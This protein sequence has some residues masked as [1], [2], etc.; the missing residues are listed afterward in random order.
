LSEVTVDVGA[1]LNLFPAAVARALDD[2]VLAVVAPHMYGCPAKIAEIEQLCRDAGVFLIDDAAH[3]VEAGHRGRAL[4]RFGDVGVISFNQSKSIVTGYRGAGGILLVNNPALEHALRDRLQRLPQP[5]NPVV[6]FLQ[7]IWDF[8][9]SEYLGNTAYYLR[10]IAARLSP[11]APGAP[12]PDYYRPACMSNLGAAIA[13]R[14]LHRFPDLRAGRMRVAG[15]YYREIANMAGVGFP[16]YA[17]DVYLSRIVLLMPEHVNVPALRSVLW[18]NGVQTRPGYPAIISPGT[19][20][21]N[22][23]M[24]SRRLL[25]VPSHAAMSETT[26]RQICRK[27]GA[28]LTQ[29][30]S[31][32]MT[33]KGSERV[34]SQ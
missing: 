17:A 22:A 15:A 4:G 25:E 27:V 16:Q 26:V 8:M 1:D 23:A 14:Q 20:A 13:C 30:I 32:H 7:F 2:R 12:A 28:A 5:I 6:I 19:S 3:V 9:I 11:R 21:P 29:D 18:R 33:E 31:N 34:V 24:W 10:S